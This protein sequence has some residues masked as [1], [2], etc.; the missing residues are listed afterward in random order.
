MLNLL[1]IET[2]FSQCYAFA[3]SDQVVCLPQTTLDASANAGGVGTWTGPPGVSFL[4]NVNDSN[5][6]VVGLLP[7]T[8]QLIWTVQF[9]MQICSDTVIITNDEPTTPNAGTNQIIC[10]DNTILSA[11]TPTIGTGTWSIISGSGNFVNPNNP[12]TAFQNIGAGINQLVWTITNNACSLYDTVL[13][14][15]IIANAGPDQIICTNFTMMNAN[16]PITGIGTWTIFSGGATIANINNPNT[17]ITNVSYG[18]NVFVWTIT[19]VCSISD[20]VTVINTKANAGSDMVICQEDTTL[21]ALPPAS[22]SGYWS[23]INSSMYGGIIFNNN[24]LFNTGIT[25]IKPG[26]HTISWTI[27]TPNCSSSD[28]ITII[29]GSIFAGY[30]VRWVCVDTFR[31]NA[32]P[33]PPIGTGIW[34]LDTAN[35]MQPLNISDVNNPFALLTNLVQDTNYVLIWTVDATSFCG[36]GADTIVIR[37]A[38]PSPPVITTPPHVVCEGIAHL[39][40]NRPFIGTYGQWSGP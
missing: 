25:N 12:S 31:L 6:Q 36:G 15:R 5:A 16:T 35:S 29:N 33:F 3:G 2:L 39:N 30:N 32:N 18:P 9:G 21:N 10:T 26:L 23:V 7:G 8:N 34:S 19:S 22:G 27:V 13:I 37:N 20:T 11:N 38:L 28:T 17:N 14:T 24:T 1:S 4:P 40:A